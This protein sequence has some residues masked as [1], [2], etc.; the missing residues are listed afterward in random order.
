MITINNEITTFRINSGQIKYY[1]AT[2]QR[3]CKYPTNKETILLTFLFISIQLFN[4]FS[5]NNNIEPLKLTSLESDIVIQDN[6]YRGKMSKKGG[7]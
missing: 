6:G 7:G 2:I 3:Y 5:I 4:Q 1:V